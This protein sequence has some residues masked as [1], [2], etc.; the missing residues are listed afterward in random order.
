MVFYLLR[1]LSFDQFKSFKIQLIFTEFLSLSQALSLMCSLTRSVCFC[2][3]PA[4]LMAH[5]Q[6]PN[7][8]EYSGTQSIEWIFVGLLG[9][10]CCCGR[11]T[12]CT[13]N[14]MMMHLSGKN[15][16]T[17]SHWRQTRGGSGGGTLRRSR[18]MTCAIC[19]RRAYPADVR[20][21]HPA[22]RATI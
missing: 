2:N 3:N 4:D 18:E 20:T 17:I 6:R 5:L 9:F 21:Q 22:S 12:I 15:R 14:I 11:K 16:A 1:S 10:G 8:K 7:M 19:A 13:L